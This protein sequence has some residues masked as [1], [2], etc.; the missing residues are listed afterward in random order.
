VNGNNSAQ[1]HSALKDKYRG[2]KKKK[3]KFDARLDKL[4]SD[5]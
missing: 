2:D 4:H 1:S 5:L 3:K